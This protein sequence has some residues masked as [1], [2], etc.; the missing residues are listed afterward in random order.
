ML[1]CLEARSELGFGNARV[2]ERRHCELELAGNN[3]GA[4]RGRRGLCASG[5]LPYL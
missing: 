3:G 4:E 1:G 5:V 2:Q